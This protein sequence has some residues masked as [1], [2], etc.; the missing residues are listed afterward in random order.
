MVDIVIKNGRVV[1]PGGVFLGGVAVEDGRIVSVGTDKILPTGKR[2][3]DA[4]GGFVLPGLIDPHVHLPGGA[5]PSLEEGCHAQFSRESEGALHGGVTS[6]GTFVTAPIDA[7]LVQSLDTIIRLGNQLS[8]ADFF[9]HACVVDDRHI[10]EEHKLCR[11]G[12]TS[13][14]HFFNPYK[15]AEGMGRF[16]PCDEGQLFRSFETI[17]TWGYP[18]LAQAH[19]EEI[20]ICWLLRDRLKTAR[21]TDLQAWTESR[22]GFVETIRAAMA[23][24]IAEAT[25]CPLYIVHVSAKET[26]ELI[27]AAQKRGAKV[28]A[29]TCPHYLTHTGDMEKE[30]GCWGKVNPSLKF[31][32]DQSALW[33]HIRNGTVTCLGTDHGTNTSQYKEKGG[34]KH[35]NIWD[36]APMICGG[37]EH[38]LPVMLTYGV[39]PGRISIEDLV[40]VCST[41]VAKTFGLYPR[42]GTLLL[43]SDAD[44]VI[45][46]PDRE[47]VVD[48]HFYHCQVEFGIYGGYRLRGKAKTTLLRGVVMVDEYDTVGR[49]GAGRYIEC[50]A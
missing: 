45:V 23:I 41:N 24:G 15:G 4:A 6:F 27:A 48:E 21:R 17:A 32:A 1:S 35:N 30:I 13:F 5:H 36:A 50:R 18:A 29:E 37:M 26:I 20:E 42:K 44:I 33:E 3:I 34:G 2:V 46:D 10:A 22:P 12:T 47:F 8:L 16:A 38:M 40:R 39:I 9:C 49:P 31:E 11:R 19:C 14:K 43:G 28:Y 25:N 7:K